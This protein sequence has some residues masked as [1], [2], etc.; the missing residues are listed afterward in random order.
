[1]NKFDL[2]DNCL[3]FFWCS[4]F[5][6]NI[7]LFFSDLFYDCTIRL[8]KEKNE[9]NCNWYLFSIAK[10]KNANQQKRRDN[11]RDVCFFGG[12]F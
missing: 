11:I 9:F 4:W 7:F 10:F 3:I 5:Y 8:E 12:V 6:L 1:M 2:K